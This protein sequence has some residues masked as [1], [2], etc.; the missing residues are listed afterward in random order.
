MKTKTPSGITPYNKVVKDTY[1]KLLKAAIQL[2]GTVERH[3]LRC[4]LHRENRS[5]I[6]IGTKVHEMVNPIIYMALEA[7]FLGDLQ[8]HFG[9]EQFSNECEYSHITSKFLRMLYKLTDVSNTTI[10]I[11]GCIFT[12]YIITDCSALYEAVEDRN[13]H[14]L[15]KL[16]PYKPKAKKKE[17]LRVA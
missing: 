1:F 4:S 11:E 5:P 6:G 14:H 15:F 16:I 12:D 13:K 17:Q 2:I 8:I 10:D 7:S 9:F 3:E